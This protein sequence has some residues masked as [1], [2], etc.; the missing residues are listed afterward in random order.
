MAEGLLQHHPGT[1]RRAPVA[2][3]QRPPR[4]GGLLL[5]GAGGRGQHPLLVQVRA[6]ATYLQGGQPLEPQLLGPA[7]LSGGGGPAV[8]G[9]PVRGGHLRHGRRRTGHRDDRARTERQTGVRAERQIGPE[10]G[11]GRNTRHQQG[12]S[13]RRSAEAFR[14]RPV[15]RRHRVQRLRVRGILLAR[16]GRHGV[17]RR[18]RPRHQRPGIGPPA[19]TPRLLLHGAHQQPLGFRPMAV[20]HMCPPPRAA[21]CCAPNLGFR[22]V[23]Y[24]T[25]VTKRRGQVSCVAGSG[26]RGTG[27]GAG[28]GAA[29]GR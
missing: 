18:P 17:E 1:G 3:A 24:R 22:S 16:A 7:R 12:R 9:G 10:R 23:S 4:R 13:Q 2:A 25:S 8:G 15:A 26:A 14:E 19:G 5:R 21:S 20:P 27:Q 29:G 6:D 28:Q 11:G